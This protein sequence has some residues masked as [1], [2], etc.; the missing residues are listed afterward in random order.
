MPNMGLEDRLGHYR[1][2]TN[3]LTV[4][5][6]SLATYW[7]FKF[8]GFRRSYFAIVSASFSESTSDSCSYVLEWIP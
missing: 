7:V 8:I 6:V 3:Q 5:L 1:L 4:L 2:S